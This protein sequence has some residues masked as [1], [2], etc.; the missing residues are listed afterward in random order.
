[1]LPTLEWATD[2]NVVRSPLVGAAEDFSFFAKEVPGFFFFLGITPH[3]QDMAKAAPNHN[4]GFFLDESALA[5]G[6]RALAGVA[7]DYLTGGP[8]QTSR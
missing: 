7:V 2:G 5:V 6:V 1:M 8:Q 3:D 4:P